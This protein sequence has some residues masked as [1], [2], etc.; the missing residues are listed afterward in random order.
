MNTASLSRDG[1]YRYTLSRALAMG[2]QT[3][4]FIGVNPST[5]D[6]WNDD[7]TIRK[8][9]GFAK[10]WGFDRVTVGNVFAYRATDVRELATAEDPVGPD[11]RR[12]MRALLASA[13]LIVPC[14]GSLNKV[15]PRL[16]G[17]FGQMRDLIADVDVPV[18]CLGR[19]KDGDPCHPLMLG[20]NTPLER[21]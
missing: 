11:N 5:A 14:W 12:H 16:C 2:D 1:R 3:V 17:H 18:Q 7:A 20:Y 13:Q 6:E 10:R 19:T 15:P 4:V 21:F 9:V 8:M